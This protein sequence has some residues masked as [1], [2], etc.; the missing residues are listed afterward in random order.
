M[1]D[2]AESETTQDKFVNYMPG[3]PTLSSEPGRVEQ[4][5]QNLFNNRGRLR[6]VVRDDAPVTTESL[7]E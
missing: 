2:T 7:D 3:M 6:A 1:K 5:L 4:V